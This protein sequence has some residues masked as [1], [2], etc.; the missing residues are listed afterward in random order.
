MVTILEVITK[1]TT[2]E[3]TVTAPLTATSR[4]QN[5]SNYINNGQYQYR[6][7]QHHASRN[8]HYRDEEQRNQTYDNNTINIQPVEDR[9]LQRTYSDS[10][11]AA[12]S[13]AIWDNM[14]KKAKENK[15]KPELNS[16]T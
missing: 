5:R 8:Q 10:F 6:P 2:L 9:P 15:C 11:F 12:T 3:T 16:H 14:I 7:N 1:R 13:A 4:G